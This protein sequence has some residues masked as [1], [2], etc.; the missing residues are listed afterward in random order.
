L[1]QCR[2]SRSRRQ[3]AIWAR[4]GCC[5]VVAGARHG[6]VRGTGWLHAGNLPAAGWWRNSRTS[7][8]L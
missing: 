1:D 2:R 5:R 6:E 4:R 7:G 3:V 8:D